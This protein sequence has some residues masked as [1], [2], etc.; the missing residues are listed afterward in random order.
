MATLNPAAQI[1][2]DRA[3]ARA[4]HDANAD[5][6]FLAI[7][8]SDG[9][10][11]VRTLVLRD[12]VDD[13]FTIFINQS[14]PKWN[15]LMNGGNYELLLWYPTL[16][17][18]YRVSGTATA[19]DADI[20]AQNWQHRPKGSKYLDLLYES[21]LDQST[22]LRSRDELENEIAKVREAHDLATI[23]APTKASGAALL[24]DRI[25]MLDLNREDAIHDRRLFKKYDGQWTA[26]VMVP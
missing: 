12:I 19:L 11:S 10:A 6:C 25:E 20:V 3:A 15:A 9:R 21:S 5:I 14:S 18:Q 23:S 22:E 4:Q 2:I 7:A 24:A 16:K 13:Q 17:R 8:D 26:R 1:R